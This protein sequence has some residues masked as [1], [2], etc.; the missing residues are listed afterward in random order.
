MM[1]YGILW[2]IFFCVVILSL[3]IS[4]YI[5]AKLQFENATLRDEAESLKKRLDEF[6][7][8]IDEAAVERARRDYAVERK[9][10]I[11]K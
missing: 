4:G 10:S 7:E 1:D 9:N 2:I 6:M 8:K 3:C 11:E 5:I